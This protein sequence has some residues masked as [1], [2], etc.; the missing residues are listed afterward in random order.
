G[1][2][3]SFTG[4][5]RA[6]YLH[7]DGDGGTFLEKAVRYGA[8]FQENENSSQVSLFGDA[9]EVQ[10]AEPLVPPCEEWGTMEKLKR[11]KEVVGIYISGHPLDDFKIEMSNFSTGNV[12][13]FHD[14]NQ[15][16]NRE[17]TF[18]A[19]VSDVQ[20]RISKSNKGWASFTVED[21]TDSFEFRIFG[22]EYLKYRHFLVP[23]SFLFIKAFI[24]EG[25]VNRD[26]GKKGDP[27]IQF[28]G[29]EL[30]HDVMD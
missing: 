10:I 19:V 2:F 30:L 20:H 17:I 9:S 16:L 28:N 6:Q 13:M 22:E 18:G 21:Y 8:K 14:L 11:E 4:T 25:W 12:S 27:R 3:D 5:H 1:G 15:S 29:F 24:R 26:T 7:S 23:N